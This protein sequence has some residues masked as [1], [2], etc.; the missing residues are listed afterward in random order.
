MIVSEMN[1]KVVDIK[2]AQMKAGG[3]LIMYKKH[4]TPAKN[5]LF[6]LD[7]NNYIRSAL[8][9]TVFFCESKGKELKTEVYTGDPRSQWRVEGNKILNRAGQCLDIRG[10]S[11]SDGAVLCAYDYDDKKNQH[12]RIDYV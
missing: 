9:D 5:Q 6:Y 4:Q 3:E 12:W 10:A 11:N 2:K 8:N 1:G 7:Q